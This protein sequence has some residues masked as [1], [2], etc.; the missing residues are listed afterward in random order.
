MSRA[1]VMAQFFGL[2]L[3]QLY[4]HPEAWARL[5]TSAGETGTV[6]EAF[7]MLYLAN[8]RAEGQSPSFRDCWKTAKDSNFPATERELKAAYPLDAEGRPG[9][10]KV[11]HKF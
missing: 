7:V 9:R 5:T 4:R 10:R 6:V 8:K 11:I 3:N 1:A 2:D